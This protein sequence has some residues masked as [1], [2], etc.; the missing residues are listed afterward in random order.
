MNPWAET[1]QEVQNGCGKRVGTPRHRGCA[2]KKSMFT[3]LAVTLAFV[4]PSGVHAG[5]NVNA[6]A[7]LSWDSTSV[8]C[9]LP[10]MPTGQKW[11]YVQV[12]G[13]ERVLRMRVLLALD[14]VR[15]PGERVLR[16]PGRYADEPHHHW[17]ERKR[18]ANW[19]P[20]RSGVIVKT[21]RPKDEVRSA[22]G[23]FSSRS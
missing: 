14:V 17:G 13:Y 20:I 3:V 6:K 18:P 19:D 11:L 10:E 12:G 2:V 22:L 4:A 5:A 1:A 8:V 15:T 9:D 21:L 7:W 23:V 16:V